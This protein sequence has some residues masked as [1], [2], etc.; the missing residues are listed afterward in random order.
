MLR[1]ES[2]F[3]QIV[4]F[5]YESKTFHGCEDSVRV[6]VGYNTVLSG[7]WIPSLLMN[8]LLIF[9]DTNNQT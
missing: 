5:F 1:S 9:Q 6:S 2:L 8:T 7:E 3:K 4:R